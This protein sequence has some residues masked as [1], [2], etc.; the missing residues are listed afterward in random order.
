MKRR[1]VGGCSHFMCEP[2]SSGSLSYLGSTGSHIPAVPRATCFALHLLLICHYVFNETSHCKRLL[3]VVCEPGSLGSPG[4]HNFACE[5]VKA[6]KNIL[7][8]EAALMLT[9]S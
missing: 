2:V 1:T 8:L 6:D 5:V 9:S 4:N 3:H 7:Q